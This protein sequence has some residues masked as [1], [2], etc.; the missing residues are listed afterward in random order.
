MKGQDWPKAI[1]ALEDVARTDKNRTGP[2][3]CVF[4]IV[5]EK[6]QRTIKRNAKSKS[7]YSF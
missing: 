3:L 7:A 4:G 1:K 6:G 5:I 2:Y